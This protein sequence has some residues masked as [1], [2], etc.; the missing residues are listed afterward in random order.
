MR[1]ASLLLTLLMLATLTMFAQNVP[2][3]MKYQA[4][5]RDAS[6][7]VLALKSVGIEIQ[8][9]A[10]GSEGKTSF[11]EVHQVTT[12]L[13][14]LFTV[15]IGEGKSL[16]GSLNEVPWS[17]DEIWMSI[18]LDPEGGEDFTTISTTKLLTVPYAFHAGTA[19]DVVTQSGTEKTSAF[20]KV[21]GNVL[22]Y[23]DYHFVGTRDYLDLNF[24]TNNIER[25]EIDKDGDI[26][27]NNNLGI[28]NN[29][30][31]GND[32][33]IGRDL[34]VDRNANIDFDVTIGQDLDVD[35]NANVDFDVTIGQDLFVD[36]DAEIG[37]DLT[38]KKNVNLNTEG[39][40][41]LN[42]GDFTVTNLKSTLLS[43]TL[44]VDLATDLNA[45]LNVDGPSN[46]QSSLSVNNGSSTTLSGTMLV[47]DDATF[48]EQVL[49]D[50]AALSSTSTTTG[51]LVV[52]GGVGVGENLNI[53]GS[54]AFG[55]PVDFAGAVSIT[56]VTESTSTST[57]AL[58]V[59]GGVGIDKR[60][61]V[62]GRAVIED[63]TES[64]A[65]GNGAL[66][67]GGGAGIAKKLNVGGITKVENITESNSATSGALVV[68]GGAGVGKR[69][70]VGGI[71]ES[72]STTTGALV[73]AGGAGIAKKLNV[74][75]VTKVDA[76]A[77]GATAFIVKGNIPSGLGVMDN[78]QTTASQHIANFENT[79][80]GNGISIKLGAGTPHNKNNFITF[81][82]SSNG[83]VGRI[84]GEDSDNNSGDFDRNQ[85]YKDD[86]AFLIT[87]IAF[88]TLDVV[89]A[90]L[91]SVQA[92]IDLAAASSSSTA[93]AGLGACITTPIP[94]LIVAAIA[95]VALKVA[96]IASLGGNLAE[97]SA[98]L[99]VFRNTHKALEGITFASGSED[100]AEYLPKLNPNE[101]FIPGDIVGVK[102]GY[103]S[104][105]TTDADMIMV[106]SLKP[107]VLGGLPPDGDVS[108]MEKVAFMGQVPTRIMGKVTPGDYILASGFN[109]GVGVAKSPD[110]MKS[111]DYKKILGVAWEGKETEGIDYINT[112]IGLNSNDMV[113]LY[114][115]Q[116]QEIQAL[117]NQLENTNAILAKLV[118][119]FAEAA[120]IEPGNEAVDHVYVDHETTTEVAV[121]H[122]DHFLDHSSTDE[123][124]Y[125]PIERNL[126]EEGL[127]LAEKN[128]RRVYEENGLDIKDHPFWNRLYTDSNYKEELF[129]I[130]KEELK[131][132]FHTHQ[133]VNERIIE[134]K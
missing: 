115:K 6:G 21:N 65:S 12:N 96:N 24:R 108:A 9:L 46:L 39:G 40:Q 14:G 86:E 5:A 53:G 127:K 130:I 100:Y 107:V 92:S 58:I 56:D 71:N 15:T 31:V 121:A 68:A 106:I 74:G 114:E 48:N 112:A 81:Y 55:G 3:G 117:K 87:D 4:V 126:L 75:G 83:T 49:L 28:G 59:S 89:I 122:E 82:N 38:V 32:A 95:D 47:Q 119:G 69:L 78:P 84:E 120:N 19:D 97:A 132:S 66:T 50:N 25:M 54:A 64:T 109:T 79:A 85:E 113:G 7:E 94:S 77:S 41:T 51:G 34:D 123:I 63:I 111:Y 43:G 10:G 26:F 116:N 73:V 37:D 90:G 133:E 102:N 44:T 23:P 99:I 72:S 2:V 125:F 98:Q 124:V 128:A 129:D 11:A 70:H 61:N 45:S 33:H 103:I 110:R 17:S 16:K 8:L 22:T 13:L 101:Q 20:W 88:A 93:C 57:G 35:R 105:N 27:I 134:R 62:G 91:E 52:N 131:Y 42:N 76:V 30:D 1:K 67:V 118:P 29:L 80:D 60:I 36:R 18:G 104:K